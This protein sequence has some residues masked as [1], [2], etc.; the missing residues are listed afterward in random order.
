MKVSNAIDDGKLYR[1]FQTALRMRRMQK[2]HESDAHK[3]EVQFDEMLESIL[4]DMD[5][6]Q[7]EKVI[8]AMSR[9]T[10]HA[11]D[12]AKSAAKSS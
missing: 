8:T 4:L 1:F 7:T 10:L 12:A 3:V 9:P 2:S 6:V 5:K 11:P